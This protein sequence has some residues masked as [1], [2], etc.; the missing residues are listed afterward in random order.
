MK[1]IRF[2]TYSTCFPLHNSGRDTMTELAN[3]TFSL[4]HC[5]Y[6]SV[7]TEKQKENELLFIPHQKLGF[8]YNSFVPFIYMS[9]VHKGG[10]KALMIRACPRWMVAKICLYCMVAVMQLVL[11]NSEFG[12]PVF[13]APIYIPGIALAV[14]LLLE[15]FIPKAV[16]GSVM[17]QMKD[18]GISIQL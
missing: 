6:E 13:F 3:T 8:Y 18:K 2:Y 7:N 12:P 5:Q 15:H 10:E 14:F 4:Y 11:L 9:I 16:I 17:A 1:T